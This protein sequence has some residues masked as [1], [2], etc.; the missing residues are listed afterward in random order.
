MIL[1]NLIYDMKVGVAFFG[2]FGNCFSIYILSC[3]DMKNSFNHLL[4]VLACLDNLFLVFCLMD[5]SLGKSSKKYKLWKWLLFQNSFQLILLILSWLFMS[6]LFCHCC[7]RVLQINHVMFTFL[8]CFFEGF[9][10]SK[11]FSLVSIY[12]GGT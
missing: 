10:F 5:Y 1:F 4:I 3:E 8:L 7:L 6:Q 11:S 2:F 12:F 9:H